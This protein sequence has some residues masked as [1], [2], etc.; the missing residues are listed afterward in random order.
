MQ[1]LIWWGMGWLVTVPSFTKLF[2]CTVLRQMPVT[3]SHYQRYFYQ[4][5]LLW[6][7]TPIL[8]PPSFVKFIDQH[9]RHKS[10]EENGLIDN[11]IIVSLLLFSID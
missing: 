4:Y 8:Q 7:A 11:L 2:S 3:A 1:G 6:I 10:M 9:L 5:C